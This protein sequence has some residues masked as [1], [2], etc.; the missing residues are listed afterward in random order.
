MRCLDLCSL[1]ADLRPISLCEI[2]L[3]LR[4]A[5]D[6]RKDDFALPALRLHDGGAAGHAGRQGRGPRHQYWQVRKHRL[7]LSLAKQG[8]PLKQ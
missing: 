2:C 8:R 7:S 4:H 6:E 3:L 5:A 1:T